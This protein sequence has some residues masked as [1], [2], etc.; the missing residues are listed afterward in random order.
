MLQDSFIW[1]LI[2]GFIGDLSLKI[3]ATLHSLLFEGEDIHLSKPFV[4]VEE[5]CQLIL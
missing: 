2:V 4:I 1:S 5:L 3:E